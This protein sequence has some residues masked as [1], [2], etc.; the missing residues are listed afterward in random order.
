MIKVAI[1][2]NIAAGKSVA[3]N[4]I[5]EKGYPV[6]DTDKLCHDILS[7]RKDDIKK[8]FS[9]YDIV[10]NEVISR[11]KLGC[12]VFANQELKKKLEDFIYPHLKEKIIEI[13]C[14]NRKENLVFVSIP[15]L[16]EVGWENLFDKIIFVKADDDV[17]LTRLM[18]RNGYTKNE[19]LQRIMAQKPQEEKIKK[20]DFIICNNDDIMSL[21]KQAD[22]IIILLKAME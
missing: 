8:L 18:K 21:Q 22:E 20:S 13:M 12:L 1:T 2:G 6:F 17:R 14:E 11:K 15:L 19:A 9:G 10:E 4:Y 3:E 7:A 16:Y 5:N